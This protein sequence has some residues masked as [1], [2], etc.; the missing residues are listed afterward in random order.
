MALVVLQSDCL[1]GEKR[2]GGLQRAR[3]WVWLRWRGAS[4]KL[5]VPRLSRQG[6]LTDR[7]NHPEAWGARMVLREGEK[8]R[9]SRRKSQMDQPRDRA[10]E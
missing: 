7:D 2:E 5:S 4:S 9:G 3:A 6:A 10:P 8:K 1:L